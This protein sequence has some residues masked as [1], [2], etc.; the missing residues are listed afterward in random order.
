MKLMAN[1]KY[2]STPPAYNTRARDQ[3]DRPI[4]SE[5]FVQS[6]TMISKLHLNSYSMSTHL[7]F[8]NRTLWS[9]NKHFKSLKTDSDTCDRC[10]VIADSEHQLADCTFPT[11]FFNIFR[12]FTRSSDKY[13][14]VRLPDTISYLFLIPEANSNHGH[15]LQLFQICVRI[16]SA[17]MYMWTKDRFVKEPGFR[18][19]AHLHDK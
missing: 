10:H 16:R 4:T 3:V 15:N 9:K 18:R 13:V 8:L 11:A 14:R 5:L 6:Y 19:K 1:R 17:A 7:H 12:D 2:S